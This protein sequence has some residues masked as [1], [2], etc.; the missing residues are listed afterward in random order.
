MGYVQRTNVYLYEGQLRALK[1]VAAEERQSVAGLVRKAVDG[2][3]ATRMANDVEWQ[4]RWDHLLE[5]VQSRVSPDVPPEE[6]EADIT[7]ASEEV[8][9]VQRAAHRC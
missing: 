5:S 2:Y 9:E 8:R 6:I 4:Q 7:A 1:H 3:L